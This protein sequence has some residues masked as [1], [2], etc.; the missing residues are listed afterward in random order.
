M[1]HVYVTVPW[2]AVSD[3]PG[4]PVNAVSLANGWTFLY[5]P[6]TEAVVTAHVRLQVM[7][8]GAS[9]HLR[10]YKVAVVDGIETRLWGSE[11]PERFIGSGETHTAQ[12]GTVT[13]S[14]SHLDATWRVSGLADGERLRLEVD[15]WMAVDPDPAYEMGR[16]VGARVEGIYWREVVQP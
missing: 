2:N 14:S 13:Y 1:G 12:D 8:E 7:Q 10:L 4:D 3:D 5:G 6:T 11:S 16:I 15:S 9:T